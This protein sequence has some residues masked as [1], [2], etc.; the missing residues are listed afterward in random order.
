LTYLDNAATTHKPTAVTTAVECYYQHHNANVHRATHALAE[1]ATF[2]LEQARKR[3]CKFINAPDPAQIIWTKGTTESINLVAASHAGMVLRQGDE[4]LLTAMEHHSNIVPWQLVAERTDAVIRVVPV[5]P[6]GT[7]DMQAYASLLGE[8]T[9]IVAMVHTSNALGTINPVESMIRM[10]HDA[11]A[12]VVVDGAQAMV[13]Q[14]IDV[15]AM[16]C[17]F[18]AFSGHKMLGPTG[19]GVLY[20]KQALLEAMPPYQGG[21]EMIENVSFAQTTYNRLPFKFEAGTPNIAGAIGMG[22]AVEYLEGLDW[23]AVAAHEDHQRRRLESNLGQIEG[24]RL[25]GTADAKIAIVSF[26]LQ[27]THPQDLGILLDQQ[28]I[29]VRSGHHCTMPLMMALGI[30]G[31]VR[32]SL[33]LY[34]DEADIDRLVQCVDRARSLFRQ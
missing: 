19:I 26:L 30:P 14:P 25:I 16:D 22:A 21:G 29:A 27:N 1:E 34:N 10:A 17:D 24:L 12:V 31:T 23:Q 32:A 3:V 9:R 7:L 8:R 15:Q 5:T 2:M 13:H 20:G 18:L 11:G 33:C 6:R 28:G 4:I